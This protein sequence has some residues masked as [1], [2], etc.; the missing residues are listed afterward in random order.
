MIDA[1]S[2]SGGMAA[3]NVMLASEKFFSKL[4]DDCCKAKGAK[5]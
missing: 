1:A 4:N 5:K 2:S 3:S